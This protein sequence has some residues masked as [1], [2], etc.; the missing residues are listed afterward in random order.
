M[1]S[2][3]T[4]AGET[5]QGTA[6]CVVA[7]QY[8]LGFWLLTTVLVSNPSLF[9]QIRFSGQPDSI[10]YGQSA[11]LSWEVENTTDVFL[12]GVGKLP[13][14]ASREVR[15]EETT[16]YTLVAELPSGLVSREVKI[17]VIGGGRGTEFPMSYERFQYP[18]RDELGVDSY[19]DFLDRVQR[20]LQ[21]EMGFSVRPMD[22]PSRHFLIVTN[23][24]L[25]PRLVSPSETRIAARRIAYLVEIE[26]RR[27]ERGRVRYTVKTLI[28]YRR[29][30]ES[31]WR[32][33]GNEVLH[34]DL[35]NTFRRRVAAGYQ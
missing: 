24:S 32:L 25:R 21:D 15:P 10:R 34:R 26:H 4:P 19:V 28:E 23:R 7:R 6:R 9:A 8:T 3:L 17:T 16:T 18:V 2:G 27:T 11:T 12:S 14:K 30:A 20:V 35:A 22:L 33:E 13:A 29:K 1:S 31:T 5:N